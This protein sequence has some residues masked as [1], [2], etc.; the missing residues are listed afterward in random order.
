MV[1][2]NRYFESNPVL[3]E[4]GS[5][6][7]ARPG[8]KH[9]LDVGDGPIRGLYSEEG[10]FNGDLFV[11]SYDTLYRVDK[12]KNITLLYQGLNNPEQGVVNMTSTAPI[13]DVPEFLFIADG[14]NLYVYISDGYAT[15]IISGTPANNDVIRIESYYYKFTNASVDA[16]TPDGSSGNPWLVALGLTT[17]AAWGNFSDAIMASGT[18]GTTYSTGLLASPAVTVIGTGPTTVSV[19]ASTPGVV[20]NSVITTETGSAMAWSNGSTLT[21]GGDPQ[22][23][24]VEMPDDIGAFD[25]ATINSFVIVLP[26]QV[27]EF[28]G[29]FYW[30]EPGETTVAP[31]NYATAERSP[32][33]VN[34][35]EVLGDMFWLPGDGSTEAWYVSTD[36]INRMQ[37]LQGVVFDRGTWEGTA[38]AIH[39]SLMLCDSG[40]A[41]FR[42]TGGT[43][44]RV[45]TPDIEEEIRNAIEDQ[46]RYIL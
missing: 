19:Q 39:E 10:S 8:L 28:Q 20:G 40:G 25:V 1:L 24:I 41:V 3:S 22:V 27:D 44:R 16:G 34:G 30:I 37:R 7:V 26:V 46:R 23:R 32:D 35:V 15:G 4:D 21:G 43:P 45:S 36:P 33:G 31:L 6:L 38:I 42:V 14:R 18:A 12:D 9:L 29:R 5:S 11:V 13:G 2:K 17:A